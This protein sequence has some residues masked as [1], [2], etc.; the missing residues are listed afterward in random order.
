MKFWKIIVLLLIAVPLLRAQEGCTWEPET[1]FVGDTLTIWFDASQSAEMPDYNSDM[2]LHWGVN[3]TSAGAWLIPDESVWPEGT[4]ETDGGGAVRSPMIQEGP[5]L[6]KIVI[7]TNYTVQTL[8][9]VFNNGTPE[10]YGDNW[11]HSDGSWQNWNITLY[12]GDITAEFISPVLDPNFSD[13]VYDPIFLTDGDTLNITGTAVIG[14]ITV[15]S[16]ILAV[17]DST[18][19]SYNSSDTLTY[20]LA[21]A[22]FSAG[23][24][25]IELI[26][27]GSSGISDTASMYVM[28][29]PETN[30]AAQPAGTVDGINYIDDSTVTLSLFA[31]Y[32]KFVFV[33]GDFNDWTVSSEYMMNI[34]SV[35]ADSVRY[36]LTVSGLEPGTEYA[37]QYFVGGELRIADPY[38]HK[39]LDPWN[40]QYIESSTYPNLKEYPAGK[41]EEAVAV[42]QTGQEPY[43]WLYD[44]YTKPPAENLVVYELLLR[45]FLDAHD[46]AT[47]IDTLGY[48]ERLGINAIELMPVTEF[49]GNSSWG[50]NP[51]FHLALDKYY[52]PADDLK[53]LVDECHKRGIAVI[54]DMVLNHAFG[55]S[56]LVRLYWDEAENCSAAESPWFNQEATHPYSVGYD[57]NHLSEHTQA[58]VDRVNSYWLTEFDI[59]GFRFDLTKGFM[60][61]GSFYDYNAE[62]ISILERMVDKIRETD[63]TAYIIFEH[64]GANDEET[65]LA[66]YGIMLWGNMNY[67]YNEATMGWN[68]N[69]DLSWAYYGTRG[70]S[71]P[72]LVTYM[73]SHDEER[74]MAKNLEW[75]NGTADYNIKDLPIALQR[76][77]I[78][79][80]FFF[81][82]P[83][84]KMIWEFGELGYDYWI[85]Y[86]GTIGGSDHRL[87]S[88]PIRW[89]YL[90]E[91]ERE[92]LFKTWAALLKLR[93]ENEV[94]TSPNTTVYLDLND[95]SGLKRIRLSHESMCVSII[96]NFGVTAQSMDAQ[97]LH[98]GYWYDYF[99]GDTLFS[100]DGSHITELGPGEFKIF[101]D[102]KLGT[103][104][105][106][107]LT[108]INENENNRIEGFALSANYPNPFNP[109]TS[110][111]FMVPATVTVRAEVY[112]VTG[113]LVKVIADEIYAP[114]SYTLQW[115]GKDG[116][117]K[118]VG[119]GIYLMRFKAG[120]YSETL[121]MLL[122]R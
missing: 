104:E 16:L 11:A 50:Y 101:T 28:I 46:F 67:N 8:H 74:L 93:N 92:R 69:S 100:A 4:V 117:G 111:T 1:V 33:I 87:D 102:V 52:G 49:E 79:G 91:P 122:L 10:T 19:L 60:Q 18:I 94:F 75:G 36:W 103:P 95:E 78:A 106:G 108:G 116:Y 20:D 77:K 51:S 45:D 40:D 3:E 57:F 15:D 53:R 37:F 97:L 31:P 48:F 42:L 23:M 85:N 25:K 54:L 5:T 72:N 81:T 56:P 107:L 109:S 43:V 55:Q 99:G 2:T 61:T 88:K 90:Q 118:P 6:W 115:N 83:G 62:R 44:S 121:K 84:P 47:L 64:L 70:W 29:L 112:N 58:F 68:S 82:Y 120:K 80:A 119:S 12:Q 86:P 39:I 98:P 41:T 105:S 110:F 14:N 17:G 9:F 32:K 89:D 113:Q 21:A 27:F 38:T 73:E 35:S 59:D 7:V 34:D 65:E 66:N 26:A 63:S 22:D 114:G 96:G 71:V 13:P 30:Y 76:Q 24:N